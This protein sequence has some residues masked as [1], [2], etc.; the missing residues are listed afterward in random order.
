MNAF[1]GIQILTLLI[2]IIFLCIGTFS[3]YWI[4][5]NNLINAHSGLF[6][7]CINNNCVFGVEQKSLTLIIIGFVLEVHGLIIAL[8][9]FF[10]ESSLRSKIKQLS[11]ASLIYSFV[12]LILIISGWSLYINSYNKTN[13]ITKSRFEWSLYLVL[14]AIISC[15][16]SIIISIINIFIRRND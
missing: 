16:T 13:H 3:N 8:I 12:S 6:G 10:K 11:I 1:I 5:L 7:T 9:I 2:S 15:L 4:K 14:V